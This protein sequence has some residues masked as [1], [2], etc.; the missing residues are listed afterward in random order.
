MDLYNKLIDKNIINK[1]NEVFYDKIYKHPWI[2]L[3]FKNVE[4]DFITQQQ[5]DFM[6]GAFGGPQKYSGRIPSMAHPHLFIT[7]ELFEL[8]TALLIE[9]FTETQAPQELIEAWLKI[10]N[11]FKNTIVKKDLS[12]CSGRWNTDPILSFPIPHKK[13]S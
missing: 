9:A 12:E 5:T 4:Q 13:A 2:G 10:D 3:F 6:T 1:I 7:I 11:S 8:R